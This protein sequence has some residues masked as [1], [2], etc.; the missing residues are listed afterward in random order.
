MDICLFEKRNGTQIEPNSIH[1]MLWLQTH[2]E[3]SHWE[4]ISNNLVLIPTKDAHMLCE[5]AM[6]AGINVNFI[7]S[8]TQID[9]I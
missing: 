8:L 2:F 7:H 9:K 1:G 5:D 3:T 6:N 4:S